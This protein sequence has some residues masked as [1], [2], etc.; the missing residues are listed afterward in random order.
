MLRY[1]IL[2][3]LPATVLALLPAT[4][5]DNRYCNPVVLGKLFVLLDANNSGGVTWAEVIAFFNLLDI[6]HDGQLTLEE[7]LARNETIAPELRG[8]EREVFKVMDLF[9]DGIIT[10]NLDI[11]YEFKAIDTNG[12]GIKSLKE[13]NT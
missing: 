13:W 2:A 5:L 11:D 9:E 6:N 8:H 3:L 4:V 7:V 1:V 10:V 12:D